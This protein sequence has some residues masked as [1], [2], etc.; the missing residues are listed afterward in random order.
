MIEVG[1]TRTGCTLYLARLSEA[2]PYLGDGV[3]L[4]G[5]IE[6]PGD[7]R[8]FEVAIDTEVARSL[9]RTILTLLE[10]EEEEDDS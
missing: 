8:E 1:T 9:G 10:I 6:K 4:R 2:W 7:Y 5:Q 3:M